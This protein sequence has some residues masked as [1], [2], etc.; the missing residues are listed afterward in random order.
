MKVDT[1]QVSVKTTWEGTRIN[2]PTLDDAV[3]QYYKWGQKKGTLYEVLRNDVM[4]YIKDN[5]MEEAA[6]KY[7]ELM[8]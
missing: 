5:Y 2:K 8:I 7:P 4:M 1:T 6:N 3:S